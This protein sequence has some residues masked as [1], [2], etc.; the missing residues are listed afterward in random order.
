MRRFRS[1]TLTSLA[2][3]V[4]ITAV[5]AC[6]P[7]RSTAISPPSSS[8]SPSES[9]GTADAPPSRAA[10]VTISGYDYH[11][12]TISVAPGTKITFTNHDQTAHTATTT[13]PG[14]DT[15]AIQPG[16]SATVTLSKPATYPY[17]CEF[18]AF[19][20]ATIVVK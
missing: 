18:H 7:R 16:Y 5:A 1:R 12:P 14:F 2:A 8:R 13:K 11:R 20:R 15:G 17:Y 19:M 4:L 10:D 3:L 9:A 6:G